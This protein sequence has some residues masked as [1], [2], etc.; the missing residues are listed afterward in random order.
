MI[1]RID[2]DKSA[3]SFGYGVSFEAEELY[4]DDGLPS[5]VECLVAAVEG[6]PPEAVAAERRQGRRQTDAP[7]ADGVA[8]GRRA[9]DNKVAVRETTVRIDTQRLDEVLN[10]S[11][12]I[13][14]AKNRLL[15]LR[16][17]LHAG[18]TDA[19]KDTPASPGVSPSALA[20]SQTA[21]STRP[22]GAERF[23]RA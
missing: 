2:I 4:G 3:D 10:L 13:G 18:K 23:L 16:N 20:L 22:E 17:N 7:N 14:L 15:C 21:G 1:V 12:Q 8:A 9:G 11:G 6:M 19:D 5:I